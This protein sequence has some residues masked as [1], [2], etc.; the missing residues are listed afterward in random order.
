MNETALETT[1]GEKGGSASEGEFSDDLE[2]QFGDMNDDADAAYKKA[3][4]GQSF[5]EM[6][7]AVAEAEAQKRAD[8][9]KSR[10]DDT[11][12]PGAQQAE[13]DAAA[14][15]KKVQD[16]DSSDGEPARRRVRV[17]S[18]ESSDPVPPKPEL[19]PRVARTLP[20]GGTT[21][22]KDQRA[23]RAQQGAAKPAAKAPAS[24]SNAVKA[25][26][27]S[28]KAARPVVPPTA[29]AGAG[30]GK[31]KTDTIKH[32]E[33]LITEFGAVGQDSVWFNNETNSAQLRSIVRYAG[34]VRERIALMPSSVTPEKTECEMALKRFEVLEA[35]IKIV[36]LPTSPQKSLAKTALE[37]IRRLNSL[38]LV[39]PQIPNFNFPGC[40]VELKLQYM[41]DGEF[42]EDNTRAADFSNELK[43]VKDPI[44]FV[45]YGIVAALRLLKCE[46]SQVVQRI[47]TGVQQVGCGWIS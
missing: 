30:R 19:S 24:S 18:A 12:T 44:R 45:R 21:G 28:A 34:Q 46:T 14:G 22:H 38:L 15:C 5:E 3:C 7:R 13:A 1:V 31:I 4:T 2:R 35:V 17:L 26:K 9:G 42:G 41:A 23:P 11:R 8:A 32:A 43:S 36:R 39:A 27:D 10:N 25:E 47:R 16:S 20:G 29:G 6:M 33:S 37:H 40:F